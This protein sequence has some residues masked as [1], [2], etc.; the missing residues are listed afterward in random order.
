MTG[1]S[2]TTF[3]CCGRIL[4][5]LESVSQPVM[6]LLEP[7]KRSVSTCPLCQESQDS[8]FAPFRIF[9]DKIGHLA[10]DRRKITG[11]IEIS[12][13]LDRADFPE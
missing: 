10:F 3:E 12:I 7:L 2:R 5:N 9:Q 6:Q 11:K 13:A 1:I 8:K 4:R